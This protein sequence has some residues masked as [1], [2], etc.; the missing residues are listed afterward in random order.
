MT[1]REEKDQNC[2]CTHTLISTDKKKKK[3]HFSGETTLIKIFSWI[4][5]GISNSIPRLQ[6][7]ILN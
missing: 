7:S 2:A 4:S 6:L 5:A 1:W 3:V